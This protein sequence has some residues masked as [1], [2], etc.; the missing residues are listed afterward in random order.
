MCRRGHAVSIP[1]VPKNERSAA[2]L[3]TQT[4]EVPDQHDQSND[5]AERERHAEETPE[6]ECHTDTGK[7]NGQEQ[8][9]ESR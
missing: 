8:E 5:R 3:G 4:G 1:A 6:D 7:Q 9:R 2:R